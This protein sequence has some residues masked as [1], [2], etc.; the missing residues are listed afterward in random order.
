MPQL[1]GDATKARIF[2]FIIDNL[3]ACLLAILLVG[4]LHVENGFVSATVL[5]LTYLSYFFVFELAF[6]RTPGK[7]L[8]GLV[9]R[10]IDGGKCDAKQVFI[11]TLTRIFEANP[12]LF[13]GLPAGLMVATS[14][15]RQRIGDM[16]AGT[17]VV[18]KD[19]SISE[20]T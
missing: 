19:I 8:Q 14:T 15:S 7:M 18:S 11:R 9:V 17:V 10:N 12:I 1:V 13:G 5:S 3:I 2:A 16:L 20:E 6:A 4:K